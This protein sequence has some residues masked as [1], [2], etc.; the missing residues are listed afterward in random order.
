[1]HFE[2]LGRPRGAGSAARCPAGGLRPLCQCLGLPDRAAAAFLQMLR[3]R[4][5]GQQR[6]RISTGS[7]PMS[8]PGDY[9][10]NGYRHWRPGAMIAINSRFP[11]SA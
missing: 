8:K 3:M 10:Q 9:R 4:D 11:I 2:L 6:P 5:G 7:W 1:M